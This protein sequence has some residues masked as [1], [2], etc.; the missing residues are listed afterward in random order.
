MVFALESDARRLQKVLPNRLGRFGLRLHPEKTRLVEFRAP[1]SGAPHS[2][3]VKFLGFR[4]VWR[5]SRR[6]RWIIGRKT[7][8]TSFQKSL[9]R[10]RA[11]L[12][13]HYHTPLRVQHQHL[14]RVLLG[15]YQYF[16]VIGNIYDLSRFQR[17]VEY[18]WKYWLGRRSQRG[19]SWLAFKKLLK[20]MKLPAA[21]LANRYRTA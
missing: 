18:E 21:R 20:R 6:G 3:S 4:Y 12:R 19:M 10:V 16:G 7:S 2:P 14:S 11:W 13:R 5:R 15:H 8:K 9:S 17:E 1:H